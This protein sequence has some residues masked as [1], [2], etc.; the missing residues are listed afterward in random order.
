HVDDLLIVD[1][2]SYMTEELVEHLKT[3]FEE[4]KLH[5]GKNHS[6]LG[7]SFDF[8]VTGSVRMSMSH[9]IALLL[10]EYEVTGHAVTPAEEWLF[11]VRNA[12][13]LDD[14]QRMR[15][16]SA[17]AKLLFLSKRVRP[18]ILTAVSFL[19]TR[20]QKPDEDDLKKLGRVLKYLRKTQELTMVM[21]PSGIDEVEVYVDASYGTHPDGKSH[22]GRALS[23]GSGA[24][25]ASVSTKQKIVTKSSTESELV[26]LSDSVGDGV[27][28]A[29]FLRSLG[30]EVKPV[31]FH[32]DNMST[33]R[34]AENGASSSR[35][36]RHMNVSYFFVKKRIANGEL[37][38]SYM[39][40]E[41]MLADILTKPIQGKLFVKL[42]D[43]LL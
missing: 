23:L 22:T 4:V 2:T 25:V 15:F 36:T 19:T 5:S 41:R 9:Y 1:A 29:E 20:V 11:E 24:V 27:G 33:I 40:T 16:H 18:D 13:P 8:N 28:A 42:R 35:R 10:E 17:V 7:I 31:I 26:G 32:Q 30:Y 34:L 3:N 12:P 37:K 39:P 21:C 6:Y 43:R 38:V 14:K